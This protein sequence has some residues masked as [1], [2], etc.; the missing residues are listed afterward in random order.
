LDRYD[1]TVDGNTNRLASDLL[2]LT[3]TKPQQIILVILFFLQCNIKYQAEVFELK[4][5]ATSIGKTW[6]MFINVSRSFKK[7]N[8]C[9]SRHI[10]KWNREHGS[11]ISVLCRQH[12]E[13]YFSQSK[14]IRPA[15]PHLKL[16]VENVRGDIFTALAATATI[17]AIHNRCREQSSA[18]DVL[19]LTMPMDHTTCFIIRALNY[20]GGEVSVASTRI[21][22]IA[23]IY[24]Q[25]AV[26]STRNCRK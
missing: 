19:F 23:V 9:V 13:V 4:R 5:G 7:W 17:P 10:S 24:V 6:R 12:R 25:Y 15:I 14:E 1:T 3:T 16:N 2:R 26:F 20:N 21:S 18:V 11:Q 8:I 22:Q